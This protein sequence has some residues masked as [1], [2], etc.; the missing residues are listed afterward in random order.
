VSRA[1]KAEDK[2]IEI[3]LRM[4]TI[5][6]DLKQYDKAV[7]LL[8]RCPRNKKLP[9]L[10]FRVDY[11]LVGCY[12]AT[13]SLDAAQTLLTAMLRNKRYQPWEAQVLLKQGS[14]FTARGRPQE[15]IRAYERV[16]DKHEATAQAGDAWYALGVIYQMTLGDPKKAK[17]CYDKAAAVAAADST[18]L[19]VARSRSKALQYLDTLRAR[20]E[21]PDTAD[22]ANPPVAR[23]YRMG[24]VFWLQLDQADSAYCH[25]KALIADTSV[26]PRYRSKSLYA[27]GWIALHALKDTSAADSLFG[28]LVAEFPANEYSKR[29]QMERGRTVTVATREDS[30]QAGFAAAEKLWLDENLPVKAA[31]A[32]LKV[33]SDYPDSRVAPQALYAAAWVCDNVTFRKDAA[34]FLYKKVC[35]KFP[36]GEYCERASKPRLR[37]ALDT[38][39]VRKELE[40]QG[41]NVPKTK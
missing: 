7:A 16:T 11:S 24:E 39:M 8:R 2:K 6:M 4:A 15:A 30:A 22:T 17:E 37:M 36:L 33:Y 38:A 9:A 3:A 12:L 10:M 23:R 14:L 19:S 1:V 28:R 29:A 26:T 27:A 40:R 13:D 34:Q 31:E 18:M 35:D 32:Y 20:I 41:K 5:H 25:F 21:R